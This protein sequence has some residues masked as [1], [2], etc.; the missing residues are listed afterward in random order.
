MP[1]VKKV[2]AVKAPKLGVVAPYKASIKVLGK[3]YEAFGQ[4]KSQAIENLNVG[5]VARGMS[6]LVLSKGDVSSSKILPSQQTMRLFSS[7]K[8]VR[9]IALKQISLRFDI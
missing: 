4:D 8:L 5:K 9:Q 2:K 6:V 1:K 7:S 3:A